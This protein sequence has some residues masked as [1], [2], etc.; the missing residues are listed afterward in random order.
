MQVITNEPHPVLQGA[1][2]SEASIDKL[3]RY[4]SVVVITDAQ[5]ASHWLQ[6]IVH[7][8]KQK[9]CVHT[10]VIPVGE[11]HKTREVKASIEDELMAHQIDRHALV[12]AVGGGVV[13]DLAGFVAAT[14]MRG[15]D[16]AYWPTSLMAIVDAA[17]GGKTGVNTA[18]GKNMIGCVAMP[19]WV[20]IDQQFLATLPLAHFR[21]AFAELIKHA[22]L[23]GRSCVERLLQEA[24]NLISP[25]SFIADH[26]SQWITMSASFKCKLVASDPHDHGQRALLNLG[27]T[28]AHAIEQAS[29]YRISHGI[30]VAWGLWCEAELARQQGLLVQSDFDLMVQ[31]LEQYDLLQP[32]GS[33]QQD[34]M[35][36]AMQTDKKNRHG[37][38][39]LV[40][41]QGFGLACYTQSSQAVPMAL[42]CAVVEKMLKISAFSLSSSWHKQLTQ[43]PQAVYAE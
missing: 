8:I 21:D 19:C 31:L 34:A 9:C 18:F 40:L 10:C 41:V 22:V 3:C 4:S 5:V 23:S 13:C 16:V 15:I 42:L 33:L 27:H 12:L 29:D 37:E 24:E 1:W 25:K 17:Y 36:H 20:L 39:H 43:D 6:K 30:A 35:V 14:Y 2:D 32:L 26:G 11:Q 7:V 28:I 38:I